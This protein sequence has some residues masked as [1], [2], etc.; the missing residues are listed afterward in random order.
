M[1]FDIKIFLLDLNDNQSVKEMYLRGIV[2]YV[3]PMVINDMPGLFPY[4]K[5]VVDFQYNKL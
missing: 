5:K 1:H 2:K 3:I 4:F